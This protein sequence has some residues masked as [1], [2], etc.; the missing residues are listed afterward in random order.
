M[1]SWN[2]IHTGK[3]LTIHN[4][5]NVF[6]S[7]DEAKYITSKPFGDFLPVQSMIEKGLFLAR[8]LTTVIAIVKVKPLSIEAISKQ[9]KKEIFEKISIAL[10]QSI[11][12]EYTSPWLSQFFIINNQ[13]KTVTTNILDKF[14]KHSKKNNAYSEYYFNEL[15]QHLNDISNPDGAFIDNNTQLSW[16]V[17]QKDIYLCIYQELS[18]KNKIENI[19]KQKQYVDA[20]IQYKKTKDTLDK[21]QRSLI[22]VNIK[23]KTIDEQGYVD[24][25]SNFITGKKITYEP[26]LEEDLSAIALAGKTTRIS[27]ESGI[28]RFNNTYRTFLALE[29]LGIINLGHLSA[30]NK[31]GIA[32]LDSMPHD[33]IW[34]QIT[35]HLHND[36]ANNILT[37]IIKASLGNEPSVKNNR[38]QAYQAQNKIAQGD[39]VF[40]FAGGVFVSANSTGTL[41]NKIRDIKSIL[42]ANQIRVLDIQENPLAQNDYINALPGAFSYKNDNKFYNKRAILQHSSVINK[43]SPFYGRSIGTN[44]AGMLFFNRG[45]EPIIFDPI[46]DRVKNAFGL[47]FGPMGSGKSAFAIYFLMQ[48][49]ATYNPRIFIIEKGDSFGLFVQHCKLL[50]LSTFRVAINAQSNDV[51]LP[52]FADAIHLTDK[53]DIVEQ[54]STTDNDIMLKRD[55]LGE[56]MI[57]AQLMIT[58]GEEQEEA[59]FERSRKIDIA[60]S[61]KLAAKTARAAKKKTVLVEDVVNALKQVAKNKKSNTEKDAINKIADAMAVFIVTDLDQ[62]LFNTGGVLFPEVDV[63]QFDV[64]VLGNDGYEDKLAVAFIA[65]MQKINNLVETKQFEARPTIILVDEAHLITTNPLLASYIV[66]IAKMWRKL[67]A[68]LWLATQSLADYTDKSRQM[69]NTM[70]WWVLLSMSKSEVEEVAKLRKLTPDQLEMI[71]STKKSIPQYTEGVVLSDKLDCLFRNVPPP[72]AFALAQTEKDEKANRLNLMKQHNCTELEAVY[73]IAQQISQARSKA[74]V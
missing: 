62:Q 5:H 4:L 13:G 28:F 73:K 3:K 56:L 45:G 31:V 60:S 71:N 33:C 58:G 53:D 16:S 15:E 52:P 34:T 39:P 14:R 57:V 41:D 65:M 68:W 42:N 51:H 30:E 67:G 37:K 49:L 64:G 29:H 72:I 55:I 27:V 38:E 9:T 20:T 25:A 54:E 59:K 61:I 11:T 35:V 66:K 8:D 23:L 47:I 1:N 12:P 74:S 7:D 46:A 43:I 10:S 44:S 50:G 18:K 63:T 26:I 32:L 69:L 21:L 70:E 40:R 6:V 17:V 22:Q 24:L 2:R 19:E 48:M 36:K